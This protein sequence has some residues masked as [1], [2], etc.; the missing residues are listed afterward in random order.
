[1]ANGKKKRLEKLNGHDSPY[2]PNL[3][4]KAANPYK[5]DKTVVSRILE[6]RKTGQ[7]RMENGK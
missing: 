4:H 5:I 1:M 2:A 3:H 6:M 7:K